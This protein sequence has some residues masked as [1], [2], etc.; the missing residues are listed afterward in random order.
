MAADVLEVA[1]R[2]VDR[3]SGQWVRLAQ[4]PGASPQ[5]EQSA[6][7]VPAA[8]VPTLKLDTCLSRPRLPQS[9]QA[10]RLPVRTSCSKRPPHLRHW[11]S[12]I[13]MCDAREWFRWWR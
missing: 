9:G 2:G 7:S 3:G 6:L 10:G 8:T 11:Y 5:V 12:K 1:D 4:L 13:G